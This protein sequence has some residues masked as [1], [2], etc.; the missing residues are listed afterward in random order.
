MV[1]LNKKVHN[2]LNNRLKVFF[3]GGCHLCSREIDMYRKHDKN[4]V[5]QFVDISAQDFDASTENLDPE[6]VY[7]YF[8][9]KTP[10]GKVISGVDAFREIWQ[11]L[12]KF[13]WM[14]RIAKITPFKKCMDLGY[15]LF[16]HVRPLLPRKQGCGPGTCYVPSK[17]KFSKGN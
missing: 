17:N 1:N 11:R 8:H 16:V 10:E 6:K 7:K 13:H 12:P 3:D 5:L 15:G 2:N 9:V 14:N 4:N